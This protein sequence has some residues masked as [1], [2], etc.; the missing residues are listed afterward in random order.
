M[1][2]SVTAFAHR[3]LVDLAMDV[4]WKQHNA[5]VAL[6][7]AKQRG[8]GPAW[9]YEMERLFIYNQFF[10]EWLQLDESAFL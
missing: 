10:I 6:G 9:G 4:C 5:I 2:R 8:D 3:G 7:V 1:S